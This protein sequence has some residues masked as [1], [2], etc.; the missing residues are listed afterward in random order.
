MVRSSSHAPRIQQCPTLVPTTCSLSSKDGRSSSFSLT[1]TTEH[2]R[3]SW[4]D[5]DNHAQNLDP[6]DCL[7]VKNVRVVD[8]VQRAQ[9]VYISR[10][11]LHEALAGHR[12]NDSR[13][14]KY[15]V[16]VLLTTSGHLVKLSELSPWCQKQLVRRLDLRPATIPDPTADRV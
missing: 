5:V 3:R 16:R 7:A 4:L 10:E 11:Q 13:Q 12:W 9:P 6:V 14:E 2:L 15:I 1:V 8:T